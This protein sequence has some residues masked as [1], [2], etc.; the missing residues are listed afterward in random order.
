MLIYLE[1]FIRLFRG[2]SMDIEFI[3][4]FYKPYKMG[5]V[6]QDLNPISKFNLML[7]F[8]LMPFIIKNYIFGFAMVLFFI[9]IAAVANEF[10]SFFNIYWKVLLLFGVFLF[11]VKAAFSP[12]EQVLFQWFGICVTKESIITGLNSVALVLSFSGAFILFI[13]TTPMDKLTYALE[14]KGM[15]HVASFVV[16]SSF[17]TIIDLGQNARAIMDS[18]KSRGIETEG[19]VIKR[20]KAYIPVMGPL[21]LNAISSTE[22]KSIAM[23]ARAFSAPVKHTYLR[24]LQTVP[25]AEKIFIACCNIIFILLIIGRIVLWVI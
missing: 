20:I 16:L 7:V 24:E 23:D 9:I 19:N 25:K 13:K 18:Q 10:K 11:L 8:G 2:G 12:G 15:S 5:N 22:E 1:Y 6:I 4:S 3:N 17:Q 14:K 21:I